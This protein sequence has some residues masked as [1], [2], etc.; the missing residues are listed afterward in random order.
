MFLDLDENRDSP[1]YWAKINPTLAIVNETELSYNA[2]D[3]LTNNFKPILHPI[4]L[5]FVEAIENSGKTTAN[6]LVHTKRDHYFYGSS[7]NNKSEFADNL[8][9]ITVEIRDLIINKC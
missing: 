5:K 7:L 1:S 3:R 6:N 2:S 8:D 4:Y 9:A